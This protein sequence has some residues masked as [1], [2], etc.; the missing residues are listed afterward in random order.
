MKVPVDKLIGNHNSPTQSFF[1]KLVT[2]TAGHE[3]WDSFPGLQEAIS[4]DQVDIEVTIQGTETDFELFCEQLSSLWTE[5]LKRE[6]ATAGV[7]AI[8]AI[9]KQKMQKVEEMLSE[10]EDQ[11]KEEIDAETLLWIEAKYED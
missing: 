1:M 6:A 5:A 7:N 4:N 8:S 3:M 2:L 11:L 10:I 9:T